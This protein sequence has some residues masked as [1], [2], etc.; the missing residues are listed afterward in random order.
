LRR[1]KRAGEAVLLPMGLFGFLKEL[2]PNPRILDIGC[3][4]NS[5]QRVKGQRPDAVYTGIDVG[6]HNQTGD[7]LAH[8]DRYVVAR[9]A[10]FAE[11]MSAFG[12]GAFDAVISN[13][14]L[15]HCE[16]PDAV[17][18]AIG[19]VLAPGGRLF[20]AFPSEAS[21]NFPSRKGTLN[22]FDDPTHRAAPEWT[23]VL[24]MLDR[25]KLKVQKA[26]RRYRPLLPAAVGLLLEPWAAA[27][28]RL[29]PLAGTWALYGFES[30]VWAEKEAG[31]G[32]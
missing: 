18:A 6:D 30:I 29:A 27:T 16:A 12:A 19:N 23:H 26:S 25:M 22:F 17:L 13:H 20:L 5:P 1:L 7:S 9:S 24:S 8:A 2:P 31:T 3:G 21:V 32:I 28:G 11:T 10:D 4:N 14:N 15:E